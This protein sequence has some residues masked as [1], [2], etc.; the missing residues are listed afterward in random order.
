VA[1]QCSTPACSSRR[2]PGGSRQP[3][4]SRQPRTSRQRRR[5]PQAGSLILVLDV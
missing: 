5:R 3:T 4:T 2:Q 1:S